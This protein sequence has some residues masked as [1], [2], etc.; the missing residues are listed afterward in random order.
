MLAALLVMT[1]PG[2]LVAEVDRSPELDAYWAEVSRAV[3]AG[4]FDG[5][6]ATCHPEG[7]LVSG[8]KQTSEPLAKALA[9]WK[10]EFLD[11]R[12]GKMKAS[13]EFRF[14]R[15]LHDE[16]TAHETGI[17]LYTT[18]SAEGNTSREYVHFEGLL[19]KKERWLILMEFQKAKATKDE[20]DALR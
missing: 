2:I 14:S 16:T 9:R 17:F 3:R 8:S 11:T 20:W 12:A 7:V 1:L 19:V 13:V 5:Y 4:D 18:T 6:R 10:P 15:R